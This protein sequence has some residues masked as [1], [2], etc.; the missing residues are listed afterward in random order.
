MITTENQSMMIDE[1]TGEVYFIPA[2]TEI[3]TEEDKFI[4]RNSIRKRQK[5]EVG[6][7]CKSNE[8]K[9]YGGFTWNIYKVAKPYYKKLSSA[10]ITRLIYLATYMDYD[11]VLI[12]NE[13][14]NSKQTPLSK[15][16][17]FW[18]MKLS[19]ERFYNFWD[20]LIV[21]KILYEK[22][23]MWHLSKSVFV[24]GDIPK[25]KILKYSQRDQYIIRVYHHTVRQLYRMSKSSAHK[26]LSYI[27]QIIP[28]INRRYNIACWNPLE[29]DL[30]KI[31]RMTLKDFC[32]IVNYSPENASHLFK[33]FTNFKIQVGD[34]MQNV[35]K[36]V[37][38]N[39]HSHG[40]FYIFINP[41]VYYAGSQWKDV[42][43]LGSFCEE[44][45]QSKEGDADEL[46]R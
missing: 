21:N 30:H 7:L 8:L 29:T 25:H 46:S 2:G 37:S 14:P 34:E 11:G 12:D 4:K 36:C 15:Q 10:T 38:G 45:I 3:I 13:L 43:I 39:N 9:I 42:E 1:E 28:Y 16:D 35:V 27:F 32:S 24:R 44:E 26:L 19:K 18:K 6:K 5:E 17:V 41:Y 20:E 22:N 40:G 31:K 33:T 23:G